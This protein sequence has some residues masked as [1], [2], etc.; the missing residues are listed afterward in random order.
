MAVALHDGATLA[1]AIPPL[2]LNVGDPCPADANLLYACGWNAKTNQDAVMQCVQGQIQFRN[3]CFTNATLPGSGPAC[4]YMDSPA[5][6]DFYLPFCVPGAQ[7]TV[8]A[9]KATVSL[10]GALI[11][12]PVP[13]PILSGSLAKNISST[14]SVTTAP[15]GR[16]GSISN[17]YVLT[18]TLLIA[19]ALLQ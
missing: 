4:V 1:K 7:P 5:S 2:A 17:Y 6:N 9:T 3:D 12:V 8:P 14:Q 15:A 16:S 19:V 13:S 18:A 11:S 10:N